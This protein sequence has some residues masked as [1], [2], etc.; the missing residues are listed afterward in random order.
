MKWEEA[1][2]IYPPQWVVV[3]ALEAKS[4][5]NVR[6]IEKV[7]IVDLF[8]ENGNQA[9]RRANELNRTFRGREFYMGHTAWERLEIK[10]FIWAGIRPHYAH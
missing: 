10:E 5:N 3:E 6:M 8:G 4:E 9:L 7:S 1:I 2:T